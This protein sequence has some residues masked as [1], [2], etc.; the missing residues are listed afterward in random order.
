MMRHESIILADPT[1]RLYHRPVLADP[2]SQPRRELMALDPDQSPAWQAVDRLLDE[3]VTRDRHI[4][5]DAI[6]DLVSEAET[7]AVKQHG[8]QIIA[9]V[10]GDHFQVIQEELEQWTTLS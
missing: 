6:I 10:F 3:V 8:Q 9:I 7:V 2:T 4:F 1:R 5:D